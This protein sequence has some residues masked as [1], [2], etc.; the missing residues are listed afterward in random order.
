MAAIRSFILLRI[1]TAL[2]ILLLSALVAG[3]LA[4]CGSRQLPAAPTLLPTAIL[5]TVIAQTAEAAWRASWTATPTPTLTPTITP[6]PTPIPLPTSTP[7][8]P[9]PFPTAQIQILEPGP[10]S[11]LASPLT[12]KLRIFPADS[13]RAQIVLYG[14]DGRI[15][16]QSS[17]RFYT[18]SPRQGI[19][20]LIRL[21]FTLNLVAE[22]ATL[23]ISTA[24]TR[25]LIQS[26]ITQRLLLLATG[27]SVLTPPMPPFERL[28]LAVPAPQAQ[29]FGGTLAVQGTYYPMNTRPL[30]VELL[31]ENGDLLALEEISIPTL[32][33]QPFALILSYQVTESTPAWLRFSQEDEYLSIPAYL[34]SRSIQLSP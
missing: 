18:F 30:Q 11:R 4:A 21:P 32:E 17:E 8:L 29:V 15:L 33:L 28:Y 20:R 27:E 16:N 19:Y 7:T 2:R 25:G 5:P 23:Q 24:T 14:E 13:M 31:T 26:L 6:T 3:P 10:M 1:R 22:R 9:P 12:L 34:Y